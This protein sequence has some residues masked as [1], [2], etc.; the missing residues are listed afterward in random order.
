MFRYNP[1]PCLSQCLSNFF[2]Y[3]KYLYIWSDENEKVSFY[4]RTE[5]SKHSECL[6]KNKYLQVKSLWQ[7]QSV[8]TSHILINL[9]VEKRKK[10][11]DLNQTWY[12]IN[13]CFSKC[14]FFSFKTFS[15]TSEHNWFPI[16][17]LN[18]KEKERKVRPFCS[19]HSEPSSVG[20]DG[21]KLHSPSPEFH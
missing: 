6:N 14:V 13:C 18:I 16:E 17:C 5:N 15:S 2:S 3:W 4:S 10:N 7:A 8:N 9:R 1:G 19:Q 20:S 11:W 21:N 12:F